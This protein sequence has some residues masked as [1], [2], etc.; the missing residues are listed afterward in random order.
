MY[1]RIRNSIRFFCVL[2][3]FN[4]NIKTM[5]KPVILCIA[6]FEQD[7]IEEFVRYHLHLGFDKIY[8]YDNE[9]IPT[10]GQILQKFGDYVVVIHLPGKN[11]SIAPQYE[12]INRFTTTYM[13]NED[14]THVC[15][16]DIDEFIVLKKHNNI[17]DFIKEYIYDGEN[18]VMC[19]GICMN[20]RYFGSSNKPANT[21]EPVTQRFTKCEEK[22]NLHV[23][24]IFHKKF[25][26]YLNP[27]HN[28]GINNHNYP[29]RSTSGK[30]IGGQ[31]NEDADLSVVQ[32]N[33][34]KSKTLEEFKHIRQRGHADFIVSP[35]EDVVANFNLYDRNEVEDLDAYHFYK[36]V[37]KSNAMNKFEKDELGTLN[38]YLAASGLS[39]FEGHSQQL[40]AQT[41]LLASYTS[42]SNVKTVL[43]IGFNAGHSSDTFLKSKDN[44]SVT[45][46][47]LGDHNYVIYGKSYIDQKYPERHQL[48]IGNSIETLPSFIKTTDTK[49]DVIFIDGGHEYEVS[50]SDLINCKHLA[51]KDTIVIMDDVTNAANESYNRGPSQAWKDAIAQNIIVEEYHF[52]FNCWR[53]MSV[54]KYII[55]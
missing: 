16:I 24:S 15:H 13:T 35:I 38:S 4:N 41:S 19:A 40:P 21:K 48:I 55:N 5:I 12:A 39:G 45:S 50:Y 49:Y 52:E 54:G 17:K 10:Y 30:I 26:L 27:P 14:I 29:M 3:L 42:K 37:L 44:V 46:F 7:Y 2:L 8:L 6:K 51:H 18:N 33:H 53:G 34:Y 22:G 36:N 25:Y 23:K 32:V 20:W 11:Y 47:D 9:D 1:T 43:E 31:F 28:P